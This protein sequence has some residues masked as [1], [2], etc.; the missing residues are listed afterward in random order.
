MQYNEALSK[1]LGTSASAEKEYSEYYKSQGVVL[2]K[3]YSQKK[4]K[5]V[6]GTS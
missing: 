4:Y 1:K 3:K 2:R 5:S 6:R